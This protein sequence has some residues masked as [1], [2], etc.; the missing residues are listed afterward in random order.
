MWKKAIEIPRLI[1]LRTNV[2]SAL[3]GAPPLCRNISIILRIC[4]GPRSNQNVGDLDNFITGI[5][6]GLQAAHALTPV[7]EKWTD[8]VGESVHPHKTIA[9]QDDAEVISIDAKKLFCLK[10]SEHW[11]SIELIGE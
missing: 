8:P 4:V 7:V 2:L 3:A 6:D 11:Y 1:A 9:I 10:E 5:C